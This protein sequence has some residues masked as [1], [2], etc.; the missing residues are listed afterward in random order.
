M[1]KLGHLHVQEGAQQYTLLVFSVVGLKTRYLIV[2]S[3]LE[4]VGD[5]DWAAGWA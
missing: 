3:S 5:Q 1:P 2:K 4:P